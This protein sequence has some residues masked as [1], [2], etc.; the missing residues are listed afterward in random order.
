MKLSARKTKLIFETSSTVWSQGAERAVIVETSPTGGVLRLAGT[1]H[2]L[3]F[4]W[5][6]FY[7][8]AAKVESDRAAEA[9]TRARKKAF[10]AFH[11][12]ENTPK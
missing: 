2:R 5:A 11:E 12:K 6:A 9:K 8:L 7:T 3:P 10:A 1:Q 4:N